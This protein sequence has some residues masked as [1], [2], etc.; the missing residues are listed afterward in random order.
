MTS[1]PRRFLFVS[2]DALISDIAW[3]VHREGNEVRYYI[4]SESERDIGDGFVPKVDDWES[5]VDWADVIVFDD[6]M[7]QGEKAAALRAAGKHVVG[8]TAYTDRLE[9]D[10]TFGQQE[11]KKHGV[12]IIPFQEFTDF[13]SAI[14]HVRAHPAA[15]VI[16]PS[17]EAQNIKRLLFVGQEDDGVDVIHVLESYQAVYADTVKVFQLQ[18]RMR[19]VEVAVGAFF[20]GSEFMLPININ[21]EHKPLFP[22]NIGPATGEMGTCMYWSEPNRIFKATLAKLRDK[23]AE[24]GYVGYIDVNCI[25]NGQGIYPLEFTA[26]FG[27][28]T[29]SIQADGINMP[30]GDFLYGMATGTLT[31]FKTRKGFQIGLR[32]VVPPFPY[33]DPK[34]FSANSKDRVIIFRKPNYEGVHIEDVRQVNGEWLITGRSGVVLIVTGLGASVKQAQA[35]AYQRVRNIHIPNMYY[36]TDIGDRWFEDHDKLHTW[37]HLREG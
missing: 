27:Y 33:D 18:R 16:K 21:F 3:Q 31:R 30:M 36:R 2:L 37:G 15:Y 8:G 25:V 19:G 4:G 6:V 14:E 11:L 32:I 26:R 12:S 28:P 20:N 24:E 10:R 34:T 1:T 9:D 35:Q 23:L 5:H 7:G 22:G 13:D 29:I 17:G